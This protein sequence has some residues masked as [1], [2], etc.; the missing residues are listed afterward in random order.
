[1]LPRG[2]PGSSDPLKAVKCRQGDNGEQLVHRFPLV[3]ALPIAS[4]A[5]VG[6]FTAASSLN[7]EEP[8]HNLARI[9]QPLSRNPQGQ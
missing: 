9:T 4:E 2:R 1:M 3:V 5:F 7:G 8:A 6:S